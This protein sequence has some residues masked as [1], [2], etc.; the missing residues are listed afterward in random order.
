MSKIDRVIAFSWIFVMAI[1]IWFIYATLSRTDMIACTMN[2]NYEYV[3]GNCLKI[4]N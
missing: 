2:D 4:D 1:M 3:D